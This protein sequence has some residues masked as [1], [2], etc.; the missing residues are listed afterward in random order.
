MK[1]SVFLNRTTEDL[2]KFLG[3]DWFDDIVKCTY[4]KNIKNILTI[5]GHKDDNCLLIRLTNLFCGFN[6]VS[7]FHFH[8]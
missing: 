5:T 2:S 7:L 1:I 4:R 8:V 3:I 6:A